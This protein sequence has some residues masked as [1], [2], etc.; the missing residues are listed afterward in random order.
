MDVGKLLSQV[1]EGQLTVEEAE[2]LLKDL[3]YE[4]PGICKIG[5]SPEAAFRLWRD[6]VLPGKAGC[7]SEG[8]LFKVL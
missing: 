8:D 4:D 3:P 1:K 2:R 6:G 7:L 5:S